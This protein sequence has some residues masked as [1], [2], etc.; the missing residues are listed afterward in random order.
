MRVRAIRIDNLQWIYGNLCEFKNGIYVLRENQEL[1]GL[2]DT[3]YIQKQIP[4]ILARKGISDINQAFL[5]GFDLGVERTSMNFPA[6][7]E[8]IPTTVCRE[9]GVKD[10]NGVPYFEGDIGIYDNGK[11]MSNWTRGEKFLVVYD[12]FKFL[13]RMKPFET[14]TMINQ[15]IFSDEFEDC[16]Q[17]IGNKFDNGEKLNG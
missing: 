13:A 6:L 15:N 1:M 5:S 17:I 2:P 11:D 10:K 16:T 14:K 8:V 3:H 9:V 12:K 4:S 7:I